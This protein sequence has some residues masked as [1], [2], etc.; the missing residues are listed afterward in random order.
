MIGVRG[1]VRPFSWP[2]PSSLVCSRCCNAWLA[3]GKDHAELQRRNLRCVNSCRWK[4]SRN[5]SDI[6]WS[7]PIVGR[8]PSIC[9]EDYTK[10]LPSEADP[11]SLLPHVWSNGFQRILINC[12]TA[13]A[14]EDVYLYFHQATHNIAQLQ[15]FIYKWFRTFVYQITVY[16]VFLL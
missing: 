7:R 3:A 2:L 5:L 1:S 9:H 6:E 8:G 16:Q 4:W 15:K 12:G 13:P 14:N 10:H 11:P